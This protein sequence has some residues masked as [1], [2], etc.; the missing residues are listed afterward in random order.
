MYTIK[1][2]KFDSFKSVADMHKSNYAKLEEDDTLD[3]KNMGIKYCPHLSFE[4]EYYVLQQLE[5]KQ[6]PK[7][8]DF[9]QETL[10][11]D[12][13]VVLKQHFIVLE[14]TSNTDLLDYYKMKAGGFP[15]VDDVIKCFISVCNP[16][17]Y[18][19]S[20]EFVHC[21]IKPGHL[22]LEPDTGL[23][24]LID[25]ELAIRKSG[26]LKG[27]SMDYASPEQHTLVEQLRGVPEN[28]PLEAISF[29]LSIDGKADIYSTGSIFYEILT[30]QKWHEKKIR[31]S[32]FNKSMPPKLEEIIMSTL[33][34]NPSNRVATAMQ[35]KQSL[36]SL[37]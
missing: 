8:Y 29:F 32:E 35:L 33:E 36:E 18:L 19:H 31:P 20:K 15:P 7:A 37:L 2:Y 26:V 27:I 5:H 1:D 10:Y 6:I 14:H 16:L 3:I 30:G 21:D 13:K 24:Y 25:F 22:L 28:V 12:E 23:V 4:D 34:E 9:G 11:K 17:N